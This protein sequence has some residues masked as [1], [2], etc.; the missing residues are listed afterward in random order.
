M[1]KI[2]NLVDVKEMGQPVKFATCAER[3]FHFV[4]LATF[5]LAAVLE[6]EK[7]QPGQKPIKKL[8]YKTK[9]IAQFITS[10]RNKRQKM[11]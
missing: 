6:F 5:G 4:W 10:S 1:R 11:N 2:R 3:M 8:K 9:S 7:R